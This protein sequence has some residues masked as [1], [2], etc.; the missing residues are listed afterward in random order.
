MIQFDLDYSVGVCYWVWV[1]GALTLQ[2]Q[3][4]V[5]ICQMALPSQV[6]GPV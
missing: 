5:P 3:E 6:E 2:A 4:R 1:L